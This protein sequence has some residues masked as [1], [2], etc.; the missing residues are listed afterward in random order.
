MVFHDLGQSL[1]TAQLVYRKAMFKMITRLFY[2]VSVD[3]NKTYVAMR[4]RHWSIRT[5]AR[6]SKQ[7]SWSTGRLCSD[8]R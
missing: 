7:R 1:S 8:A 2:H 6:T 3:E 4:G 5:L